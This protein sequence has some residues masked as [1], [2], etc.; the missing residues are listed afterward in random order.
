MPGVYT[1]QFEDMEKKL[2]EVRRILSQA[3]VTN[4]DIDGLQNLVDELRIN[5]TRSEDRLEDLDRE[6]DNTTQRI[7]D[8]NQQLGSLQLNADKLREDAKELEK[9]ATALQEE[10]VEGN[11]GFHLVY[12]PMMVI[13]FSHAN[14]RSFEHHAGCLEKI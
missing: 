8:A 7:Y 14:Y 6:I 11:N 3:N 13:F 10:N 4:V 9:N 5:L 1:D 2:D 12:F